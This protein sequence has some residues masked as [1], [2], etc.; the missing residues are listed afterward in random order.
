MNL[1]I[2]KVAKRYKDKWAV[3][4]FSTEL[5]SGVYG[6]LGPN[7]SGKTT[8]MRIL[9]DILRPTSGRIL[10]DGQDIHVLGDRYRDLL[11]YLPQDLGFYK[12]FNARRFLM[13]IAALKGIPK[14]EAVKKVDEVLE[15][16][17]LKE[18]SHRKIGT[19]SGGMRQRLGIAQA[20]LNDPEI[21]IL[22]EP[23]AGLDPR[24]RIRFRN[25]ISELSGRRIVFLST[26]IVADIEYIAT[27]TLLMKE[28]CL[29]KRGTPSDMT[30]EIRGKVWQMEVPAEVLEEIKDQYK[31][32]S[33][34]RRESGMIEA[35]IISDHKPLPEAL[36]VEPGFEDMYLYYFDR[37]AEE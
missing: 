36:S 31:V 4:D 15:R 11:G 33:T 19:F 22:D 35:R 12:N 29:I 1:T 28:G 23:T 24:E 25:L 32:G 7:G 14:K 37:E 10:L 26:H 18:E 34:R 30:R 9:V 20:I 16:V 13:Y 5:E 8:L 3:K 17:N 2:E 21:M 6:L 27:D